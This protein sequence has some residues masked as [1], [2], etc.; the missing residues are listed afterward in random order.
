[1]FPLKRKSI[2]DLDKSG[3][4]VPICTK[5]IF[6]KYFS[7]HLTKISFWTDDDKKNYEDDLCKV[8][9]HYF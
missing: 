1:M 6:L 9:K 3:S 5:N 2:I 4:F 8:L 7:D